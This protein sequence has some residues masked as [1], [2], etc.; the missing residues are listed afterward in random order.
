MAKSYNQKLKIVY[1]MDF[2]KSH[3][4]EDHLVRT[5]DI[6]AHLEAN[7]IRAERKTIYDDIASLIDYGMDIVTVNGRDGGYYLAS[8]DFELAELK[9]LVDAV[10]SSKFITEKKSRE[11]ISKLEKLANKNDARQLQ[12]QVVVSKRA[13]APNE[14]IYYNIDI[15]YNGIHRNEKIRFQYYEWTVEK[16]RKLRRDG[17]F[18][19]VS[20]WYLHWNSENYYL[21]CFDSTEGKIKHFRV[22]KML[23]ISLTGEQRDGKTEMEQMDLAVYTRQTFGMFAGK[24]ETVSIDC[25]NGMI[26]V[27][28]D[29]FGQDI[30]LRR[31]D[32]NRFRARMNI[33]VSPQF[34]GWIAGLGDK[35]KIAAPE[36]VVTDFTKYISG[37]TQLYQENLK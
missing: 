30:A 7:G 23:H 18:Y 33:A 13:K 6:I 34:Y 12:R 32:E 35:V 14:S 24:E 11:L 15:L 17:A 3:S 16:E 31:L 36:R 27:V 10:Q 5:A 20:P 8:R 2:L 9:L 29:R 21:I 22:D 37:L 19:E 1:I 28:I 26:G 25:D 4:D